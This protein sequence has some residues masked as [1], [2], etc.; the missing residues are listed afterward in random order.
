MKFSVN[1]LREFINPSISNA[2]LCD[3]L[4]MAGLEVE[5]FT[6][7]VPKFTNVFTAKVLETKQH[8]DAER[9]KVCKVLS[10]KEVLTIVCG[11]SNVAPGL[12]VP[13]AIDGAK[14]QDGVIKIKKSK[15]RG[16]ESQGMICS[17]TELG[18]SETGAG[19]WELPSDTPLDVDLYEYLK[20]DDQIIELSITPNRGDCLS[21]NGIAREVKA[22]NYLNNIQINQT[23][24]NTD[25]INSKID[26]NLDFKINIAATDACPSYCGRV[27]KNL[28]SNAV[29]PIWMQE[30]LRRSGIRS[31]YPLV[32]VT[33]YVMLELGQPMHA[34]DLTKINKEINVRFA[35]KQETL[36][37]LDNTTLELTDTDLVICDQT[38]PLALAGIKGGLDSGIT[39]LTTDILLESAFFTPTAIMGKARHYNISSDGSQRWER[40]VDPI[41]DKLAMDRATTLLLEIAGTDNTAVSKILEVKNENYYQENLNKSIKLRHHRIKR[42][43]GIELENTAVRNILTSLGLVLQSYENDVYTFLVPS[44]RFDLNIEED[45]LE[46]LARIHG[47][48]NIPNTI[49]NRSLDLLNIQDKVNLEKNIRNILSGRGYLETINYSFIDNE[50][51]ADF[52]PNNLAS[53]SRGILKL[54][55]PISSEM[56]ELRQSLCPGLIK[57]AK[58]NFN[59]QTDYLKL[60][61]IGKC[62]YKNADN[63]ISEENKLAGIIAGNKGPTNWHNKS[64]KVDF[65][66]IKG[67]LEVLFADLNISHVSFCSIDW[68]MQNLQNSGINIGY[69]N[70][71]AI[72]PGQSALI[73]CNNKV[74]GWVGKLHPQV[75]KKTDIDNSVI[76]FELSLE[77][78]EMPGYTCYKDVSKM[79]SIKRDLA[80]L[81]KQNVTA[82]QIFDT[83]KSTVG[84]LLKNMEIFD[85]YQGDGIQQ[86]YKSLAFSMILQDFD[87]T[88]VDNEIVA[89][90]N[91]VVDVITNKLGGQLRE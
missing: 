71:T 65:F 88:L 90:I 44:Y 7:A 50:L 75:S 76:L 86:G 58:Y 77:E 64:A 23:T 10:N 67:D 91:N 5:S 48:N 26:E 55:N 19:I 46:E 61:E 51:Q 16:I 68:V 89:V 8:P 27:I 78:L 47:Y 15:I 70:C 25:L 34:F 83:V 33:N 29:T 63:T 49:P 20:L 52:N 28:N 60:Y 79:P 73:L 41:L 37:L 13:L 21:V 18:L 81:F 53:K 1:W 22:I 45:L 80:F 69:T 59:H 84:S 66:D 11:A 6:P 56:S 43:L 35:Y 54:I 30:K 82:Q 31:I 9:L 17:V 32:D 42:L 40:G 85:V 2:Q 24:I 39:N 14:L 12:T 38:K 62:F 36:V 4:T 57:T 3:Q 87:K 74:I 72:H